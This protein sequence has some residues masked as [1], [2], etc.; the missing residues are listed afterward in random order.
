MFYFL[1]VARGL[2]NNLLQPVGRKSLDYEIGVPFLCPSP[3]RPY[4]ATYQN[5]LSANTR[6]ELFSNMEDF[7]SLMGTL[8][9][10]TSQC[11][12]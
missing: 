6:S 12:I 2:W 5:S 3:E 4:L 10:R 11:P 8:P 1:L 7:V 9:A